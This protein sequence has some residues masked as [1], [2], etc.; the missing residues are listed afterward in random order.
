MPSALRVFLAGLAGVIASVGYLWIWE[1]IE[2]AL[3]D[4]RGDTSDYMGPM[5]MLVYGYPLFI[6]TWLLCFAMAGFAVW[7]AK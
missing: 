7:R 2:V 6:I 3:R 5:V 1:A 4:S